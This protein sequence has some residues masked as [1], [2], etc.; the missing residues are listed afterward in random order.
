MVR[1]LCVRACWARL[2]VVEEAVM[3]R[4]VGRLAA[5]GFVASVGVLVGS[6]VVWGGTNHTYTPFPPYTG[7]EAIG[8]GEAADLWWAN[9]FDA[10]VGGEWITRLDAGFSSGLPAGKAISFLLY[11]DPNND[12]DPSDLTLLQRVDT[13]V[14][15]G[16][17]TDLY[18]PQ[19]VFIPPTYVSGKFFV[20]VQ[21]NNVAPSGYVAVE[22][23]NPQGR[24]FL[25]ANTGA[26]V[27]TMN[28]AAVNDSELPPS[29]IDDLVGATSPTYDFFIGARGRPTEYGRA[30]DPLVIDSFDTGDFSIS[31]EGIQVAAPGAVGGKHGATYLGSGSV[32]V[33]DGKLSVSGGQASI[34]YGWEYTGGSGYQAGYNTYM[35]ANLDG[36]DLIRIHFD[37]ASPYLHLTGMGL[38]YGAYTPDANGNID[39]PITGQDWTDVNMLDLTIYSY[40]GVTVI[41]SITLLATP[42]AG[43]VN[44]DGTIDGDDYA[45]MDRGYQLQ[46]AGHVNGDL[47]GD[48]VVDAADYLEVDT[49]FGMQGGLSAELL[50][51]RTARFGEGYV[52]ELMAAV[53][54]PVGLAWV[55]VAA[56]AVGGR[57]RRVG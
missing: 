37:E 2:W 51:D 54:E 6:G 44:G 15:T 50:A 40:S 55:V 33:S 12:G 25:A 27:G 22:K 47:N 53:P 31:D 57:R 28:P 20:A 38:A 8:L 17:S 29:N 14:T 32:S 23:T 16:N 36:Y 39:I 43:D 1:C 34:F 56:G 19:S 18:V 13:T 45:L 24:S 26:L 52:A 10:P 46:L 5:M 30:Q 42:I 7:G 41:D 21:A 35:H 49:A 3:L 48:G 11:A 9:S 4:G